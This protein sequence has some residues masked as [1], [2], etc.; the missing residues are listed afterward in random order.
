MNI[1]EDARSPWRI[2]NKH[3][4]SG[5]ECHPLLETRSRKRVS[6]VSWLRWRWRAQERLYNLLMAPGRALSLRTDGTRRVQRGKVH[7][8]EIYEL[9]WLLQCIIKHFL[10]AGMKEDTTAMSCFS[11]L[12]EMTIWWHIGECKLIWEFWN[13]S[14]PRTLPRNWHVELQEH[15]RCLLRPNMS[16]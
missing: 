7:P 12:R 9:F 4:T 2:P 13:L 1:D 10:I 11:L 16:R 15:P 8:A 5:R 3:M 6:S 14:H